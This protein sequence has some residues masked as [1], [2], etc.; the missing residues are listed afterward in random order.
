MARGP[1]VR[2]WP[3]GSIERIR[4]RAPERPSKDADHDTDEESGGHRNDRDHKEEDRIVAPVLIG[5]TDRTRPCNEVGDPQ[6]GQKNRRPE[7]RQHEHP[8]LG[9][10]QSKTAIG[11][12][13]TA[14]V[15]ASSSSDPANSATALEMVTMSGNA[16]AVAAIRTEP[17]SHRRRTSLIPTRYALVS[18]RN[19]LPEIASRAK[20]K[21]DPRRVASPKCC[22]SPGA[23][24]ATA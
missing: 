1:C 23:V 2:R 21:R 20:R 16:S 4:Q 10:H 7:H 3:S 18:A 6:D 9:N 24:K 22:K 5:A 19:R 13:K 14:A 17:R 8:T 12:R 15:P 11:T